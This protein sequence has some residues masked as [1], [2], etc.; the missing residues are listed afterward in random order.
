MAVREFNGTTDYLQCGG[1]GSALADIANAYSI[2]GIIKP[3]VLASSGTFV[4]CARTTTVSPLAEMFDDS[5]SGVLGH[6]NYLDGTV[7]GNIGVTAT[8]WQVLGVNKAA[9][10]NI[11]PRFHQVVFGNPSET[12]H[13]DA[14]VSVGSQPA[15]AWTITQFGRRGT[16]TN[17]KNYRLAVAAVF[18]Y[19]LTDTDYETICN[20]A[21]TASIAARSPLAL[22]E[23][24]QASVA[25]TVVDLIGSANEITRSG[26]TAVTGDD[27]P[28]TYGL[29]GVAAVAGGKRMLTM[30]VG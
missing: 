2:V 6:N 23:F 7:S 16:G 22:W 18:S 14:I 27:P 17:F 20:S 26:T 15:D 29:G 10:D 4:S 11:Y 3:L 24:N 13:L 5:S 21:S 19:Q 9:G 12:T 28:W 8:E 30:G 1:T 25:T